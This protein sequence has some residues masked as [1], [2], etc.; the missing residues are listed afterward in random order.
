MYKRNIWLQEDRKIL[1]GQVTTP[2][3][4]IE[5]SQVDLKKKN[6]N[7]IVEVGVTPC[8]VKILNFVFTIPK[9][10]KST[11]YIV[12]MVLGVIRKH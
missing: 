10:V 4:Q 12:I 11:L 2:E 5:V 3:T 1:R 6:F 9:L 7:I 8:Y